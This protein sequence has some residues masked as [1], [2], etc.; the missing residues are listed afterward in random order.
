MLHERI[1][2]A[3]ELTWHFYNEREARLVPTHQFIVARQWNYLIG[4]L[5]TRR[6]HG[7]GNPALEINETDSVTHSREKGSTTS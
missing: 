3:G 4:H 7:I 5:M 1:F 6:L 2:L